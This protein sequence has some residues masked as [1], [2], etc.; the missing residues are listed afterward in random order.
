[1][2]TL[3]NEQIDSNVFESVGPAL[4]GG[5]VKLGLVYAVNPR[6]SVFGRLQHLCRS[7][8]EIG[9]ANFGAVAQLLRLTRGDD[10]T[11]FQNIRSL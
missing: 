3:R 10:S 4:Q 11:I 1:M 9:L 6:L 5:G 2:S 8:P 7:D